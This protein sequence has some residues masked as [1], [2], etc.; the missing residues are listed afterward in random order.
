MQNLVWRDSSKR[1]HAYT[2]TITHDRA[3]SELYTSLTDNK[4]QLAGETDSGSGAENMAGLLFW[5]KECLDVLEKGMPR[6]V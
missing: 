5:K 2:G 4:Q 3:Y 1:I 6:F